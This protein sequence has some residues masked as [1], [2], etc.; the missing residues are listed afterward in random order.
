MCGIAGIVRWDGGKTEQAEFLNFVRS[1]S[2]RGPDGEGGY[3]NAVRLLQND[4]RAILKLQEQLREAG[5]LSYDGPNANNLYDLIALSSG[6]AF[7][8]R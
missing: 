8:K 2:H 1:M 7:Q 6:K 5:L 4:R 3:E